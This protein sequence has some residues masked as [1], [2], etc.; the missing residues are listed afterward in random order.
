MKRRLLS[1]ITLAALLSVGLYAFVASAPAAHA[2]APTTHTII[3]SF[4][5]TASAS[6]DFERGD[7]VGAVFVQASPE[8]FQFSPT[9]VIPGPVVNVSVKECNTVTATCLF[10]GNV[11]TPTVLQI[12]AKK[13]TSATLEATVPM[14]LMNESGAVVASTLVTVDLTWTG[15]GS[16]T[17]QSGSFRTRTPGL[18][19]E[20]YHFKGITRNATVS[21][22]VAYL[23]PLLGATVT[24]TGEDLTFAQLMSSGS[25]T[26]TIQRG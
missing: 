3:R 17:Y 23:S 8:G 2:A 24:I 11:A 6:F 22:T 9:D 12:D 21:G 1:S 10:G 4:G 20:M 14:D 13:L 19:N 5:S 26:F 25:T 7:V 16:I 15:V 18:L